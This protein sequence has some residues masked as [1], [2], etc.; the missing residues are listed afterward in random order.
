MQQRGYI[1]RNR[2]NLPFK[3]KPPLTRIPL[4]KS[5]GGFVFPFGQT[6]HRNGQG[7]ILSALLQLP[8][9][10]SQTEQQVATNSRFV[11]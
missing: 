8:L 5:A 2:Y 4:V 7:S 11:T 3:V 9:F 10:V 6:G 1:L